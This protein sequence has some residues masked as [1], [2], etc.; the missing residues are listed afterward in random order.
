[1]KLTFDISVDELPVFIA[2]TGE[3]FQI[4]GRRPSP[5]PPP[6]PLTP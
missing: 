6:A 2:E 3:Q 1:M 5:R 4:L